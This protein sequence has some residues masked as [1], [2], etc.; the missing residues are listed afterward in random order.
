MVALGADFVPPAET[1]L[2][3][4][5]EAVL[6]CVLVALGA[7]EEVLRGAGGTV[8]SVGVDGEERAGLPAIDWKAPT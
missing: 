2:A 3:D 8:G 4:D 6:L 5:D 7:L 1:V